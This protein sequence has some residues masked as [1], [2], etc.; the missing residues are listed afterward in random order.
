V[1]RAA[2]PPRVRQGQ[3]DPGLAPRPVQADHQPPRRCRRPGG[4]SHW[5][6]TGADEGEQLKHL[7]FDRLE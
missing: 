1:L 3:Q 7:L 4:C 5:R 6:K 2:G